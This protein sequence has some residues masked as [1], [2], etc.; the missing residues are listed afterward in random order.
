MRWFVPGRLEVLGKHTDYM[1]GRSLL[2][3]TTTLKTFN[4]DSLQNYLAT[5][6]RGPNMVVAAA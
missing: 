5:H 1:G 4:R 3:T 2:G 6:Y